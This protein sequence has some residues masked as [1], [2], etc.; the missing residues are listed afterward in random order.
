MT[1]RKEA[2]TM[3]KNQT[4][5][6]QFQV[7]TGPFVVGT[8]LIGVGGLLAFIGVIV[9]CLHALSQGSRLVSQLE[10]PPNEMARTKMNQL[11]A[12]ATAGAN[13]WK[14]F[15]PSDASPAEG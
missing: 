11:M 10:T 1:A 2:V 8:V 7:E 13:A 14:G 15:A 9:A 12:A 6:T 4:E 3:T 5:D